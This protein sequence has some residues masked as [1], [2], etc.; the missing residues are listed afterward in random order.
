MAMAMANPPGRA[1]YEPNSWPEDVGGPR[2]D[3]VRGF[4]SYPVQETGAKGRVRSERF[5]DHYSQAGQFYRS[6]TEIE[7]HHIINAF[8]FELSKVESTAIRVRMVAGL[9][10]VHEGLAGSVADGLG[11]D[12][13]PDPLPAAREPITDL[14]VSPALSILANGPTNFAGRKIGVLVSEGADAATLTALRE[15]ASQEQVMLEF[16]APAIAGFH[17]S[18][19]E[20][21]R[22]DQTLDG[23]PSVLYD[24]VA[25]VASEHAVAALAMN[26]AARDFVTDAYSHRKFIG[27]V[28][29]AAPLL[30]ATG[31]SA[32]LDAGFVNLS[33]DGNFLTACRQV[34]FWEREQVLAQAGSRS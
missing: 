6:Q 33:G 31:L 13:M 10:N 23:G 3:P 27:Y 32:V 5:A 34:R 14:P 29:A 17:A 15:S 7:R 26:P 12:S 30:E 18:D 4:A 1:N 25:I 19:G 11:F 20:L 9:R 8:V 16:V 21:I 24:A 22:A 28:D 2:E